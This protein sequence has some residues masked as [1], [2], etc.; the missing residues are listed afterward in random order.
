[1]PKLT[2]LSLHDDFC[3]KTRFWSALC[4]CGGD[5]GQ[6]IRAIVKQTGDDFL[7]RLDEIRV[8]RGRAALSPPT[9]TEA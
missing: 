9:D 4:T 6:S 3:A 7:R 1:M 2:D 5:E 8:E